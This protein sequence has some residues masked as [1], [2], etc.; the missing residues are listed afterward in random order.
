MDRI[1]ELTENRATERLPDATRAE[2]YE[3][4]RLAARRGCSSNWNPYAGTDL[5]CEWDD[6]YADVL[7]DEDE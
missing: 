1:F 5:A 7:D 4:G 2:A 6:G 3:Q